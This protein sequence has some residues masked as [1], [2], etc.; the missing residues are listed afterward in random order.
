MFPD[1]GV[2]ADEVRDP[3]DVTVVRGRFRGHGMQSDAS[4]EQTYGRS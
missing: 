4:F 1:F 3:G 2:E